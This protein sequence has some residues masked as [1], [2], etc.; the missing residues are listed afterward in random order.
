MEFKLI[1]R[2][3]DIGN[4]ELISDLQNV[5]KILKKDTVSRKEYEEFG[6]FSRTTIERRFASWNNALTEAG[7]KV[8]QKNYTNITKEDYIE[9][10]RHLA[11]ALDVVAITKEKYKEYGKYSPDRII[12]IFGSWNKALKASGLNYVN[13]KNLSEEELFN[14]LLDVW[15]K[16]GRQPY[17]QDMHQPLSI[18]SAKPY[19]TKYGS[20][21][22]ALERFI[23]YINQD[24]ETKPTE[25]KI[26][27]ESNLPL[28]TQ[29]N[30]HKTVRN[31]NL[32]LRYHVLKRDNFKCS[33]CGRSP[34]KD[35]NIELHID[36]I[37]PWSKGGETVIENLRTLCSDCN[38]GKSNLE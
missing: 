28:N 8:L 7:L 38:L 6:K 31:I 27:E 13:A 10:I 30:I 36:H 19:V 33:I 21:Y 32:R 22:N 11:D 18:C 17:Y 9:D 12:K 16:L 15:Q 37:I 26:N 29:I 34:A 35:P 14:N 1:K 2:N 4:N 23:E 24:E 5:A 3:R 20:W 25:T